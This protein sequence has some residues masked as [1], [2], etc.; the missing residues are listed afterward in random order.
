MLINTSPNQRELF[1]L[2]RAE[3]DRADRADHAESLIALVPTPTAR[4]ALIELLGETIPLKGRS[5]A[6]LYSEVR[7]LCRQLGL[8]STSTSIRL[9]PPGQRDDPLPGR[10]Q[11]T[12][13]SLSRIHHCCLWHASKVD[14]EGSWADLSS[15]PLGSSSSLNALR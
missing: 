3:R 10:S 6:E 14:S 8:I 9:H 12:G 4:T 2:F 5:T 13:G 7:M 15:A 1:S 11:D